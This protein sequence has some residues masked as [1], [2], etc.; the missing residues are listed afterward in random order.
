MSVWFYIGIGLILW[1]IYDMYY[2]VTWTFRPIYKKY[3]PNAYWF[4]TLLWI[5]VAIYTTL[6]GLGI[7]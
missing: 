6:F 1:V 2:G 4:V 3:E 5:I 7:V